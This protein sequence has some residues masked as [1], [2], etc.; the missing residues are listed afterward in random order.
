MSSVVSPKSPNVSDEPDSKG[1]RS[2]YSLLA[3]QTQNAFN[4]NMA[5]FI[6]VP[7]AAWLAVKGEG[8]D[9]V[10]H[11]LGALMVLPYIFLASFAG[12]IGDRFSKARVIQI[13]I[14]AQLLILGF[15]FF[16]LSKGSMLLAIVAF[17]LLATQSAI[18]SPAKMG[19]VK[20]LV[21]RRKL[22]F[23]SGL[24]EMSVIL[25]ILAGQIFSVRIFDQ[26]LASIG[27]GWLAAK[28]PIA[29]L[30]GAGFLAVMFSYM[31]RKTEAQGKVP[32]S[33]N[34]FF[35]QKE[36]MRLLLADPELRF[37]GAG[38]AFFWGFASLINLICTKA[39]IVLTGGSEGMG[40]TLSWML[41]AASGGIALGS[42]LAG[43]LSRRRLEMGLVGVGA[44]VLPLAMLMMAGQH[45]GGF[46][47]HVFLA[48][49]GAGGA[50]IVVPLTAVLQDKSPQD[51]RGAVIAGSNLWNNLAGITAVLGQL[52]M[53]VMNV[54]IRVQLL[55]TA[56]LCS[57]AL[58]YIWRKIGN[59][60]VRFIGLKLLALVY[61]GKVVDVE[62]LPAKGGV[63]LLPNHVTYMDAFVLSLASPRPVRFV[64]VDRFFEKRWVRA[65]AKLFDT[66]PIS[67]TRA[68]E[69]IKTAA[70][71]AKEG[72][73]VC[74]FPEG[75]LT[76]TGMLNE[77][78]KGFELIARKADVPV[79]P[80]Y[81]DG[82]WGS[83]FSYA[84]GRFIKKTPRGIPYRVRVAFGDVVDA[85]DVTSAGIR[86]ELT[87]LSSECYK[88]RNIE[89][90]QRGDL[91]G[92]E[93]GKLRHADLEAQWNKLKYLQKDRL[94]RNALQIADLYPVQQGDIALLVADE[95]M[96]IL[97]LGFLLPKIAKIRVDLI[98]VE[99]FKDMGKSLLAS[100]E[101]KAVLGSESIR[102]NVYADKVS[103]Y[104]ADTWESFA[105]FGLTCF[106]QDGIILTA[107]FPDPPKAEAETFQR[108]CLIGSLG[109]VL[110]GF[111]AREDAEGWKISGP[112]LS[113]EIGLPK[114][115]EINRE[116][117][118]VP[119]SIPEPPL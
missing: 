82:L 15:L 36:Q 112:A 68:K 69:A 27:D 5:R 87:R 91:Q 103:F 28:G 85:C 114:N 111:W 84:D 22:T 89:K 16:A 11:M 23:A 79:M 37:A 56:L 88:V 71:A 59:H 97:V 48:L 104:F 20:E 119:R 118:V 14:W 30:A 18:L 81:M 95:G 78:K 66:I 86:S 83:I 100:S 25:A 61:R 38:V 8:S 45:V 29:L 42:G 50:F 44:F 64:M 117:F 43:W 63:I 53:H 72:S 46:L 51:K 7:L 49:G 94:W 60:T 113:R 115:L 19:I 75:Q 55:I 74:L 54:P 67:S 96:P 52:L 73:V 6:L 77:I 47:F 31:I 110:P 2:F 108:G 93:R 10:E 13:A 98:D 34:V 65:F 26:R 40:T 92:K 3:L 24:M 35:G 39:A 12:W 41:V 17:T 58:F 116:G 33:M 101:Y 102:G 70:A 109:S 57:I 76:R 9:K 21:G 99:S 62:K 107:S 4:D 105:D 106:S 1:W 32:F 90:A 80:V